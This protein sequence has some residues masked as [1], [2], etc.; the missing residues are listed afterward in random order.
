MEHG[1]FARTKNSVRRNL[2]HSSRETV[3][4]GDIH[5]FVLF[6]DLNESLL[7]GIGL[8]NEPFRTI[9]VCCTVGADPVLWCPALLL[10]LS[11]LGGGAGIISEE[12]P[13][14]WWCCCCWVSR[15]AA[16]F[17]SSLLSQPNTWSQ[18]WIKSSSTLSVH[19]S[20]TFSAWLWSWKIAGVKITEIFCMLILFT[21]DLALTLK[22]Q[23]AVSVLRSTYQGASR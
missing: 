10:L 3:Y 13:V 2:N 4:C 18:W 5:Q 22:H 23:N 6:F 11:S 14:F 9:F 17:S 8:R 20:P 12:H 16:S 7:I 19:H 15:D 1:S 21:S